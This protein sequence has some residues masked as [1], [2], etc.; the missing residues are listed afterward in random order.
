MKNLRLSALFVAAS[1][2][3]GSALA[4]GFAPTDAQAAVYDLLVS[5]C[6]PGCGSAP[7]GTVTVLPDADSKS[8][9][10]TVAL[11]AAFRFHE[12]PD[13][14]HHAL[15]FS[16]IGDPAVTLSNL[17]SGFTRNTAH[18]KAPPFGTFDY[19][20]NCTG[21]GH[22]YNGGLTGPLSF[23]VTPL[24]G[25]LTPSSLA[26]NVYHLQNIFFTTDIVASSGLTGNIGAV[27][28]GVP[29]LSTWAMMIIG[30]GG[31]GLQVRRRNS[32]ILATA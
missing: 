31:V 3:L 23:E 13:A 2:A 20:I 1:V 12:N 19:A 5:E 14:N 9:D 18:L 26:S 30:F 24:S 15:A 28:S 27:T 7:W 22:G 10:I 21:C 6:S 16:L 11:N 17:S 25:S 32:A 29:E 8:L 4:T